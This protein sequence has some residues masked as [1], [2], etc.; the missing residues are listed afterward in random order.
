[1]KGGIWWIP[2]AASLVSVAR[3]HDVPVVSRRPDAIVADVSCTTA[4]LKVFTLR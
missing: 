2:G 3:N 4:E 1:M